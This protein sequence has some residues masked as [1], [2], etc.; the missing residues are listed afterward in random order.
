MFEKAN[1]EI[2][3]LDDTDIIV[4]SDPTLNDDGEDVIWPF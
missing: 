3:D 1:V 2:Y 4:T